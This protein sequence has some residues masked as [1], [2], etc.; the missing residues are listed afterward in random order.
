MGSCPRASSRWMR[1]SPEGFRGE[2]RACLADR[3]HRERRAWRF[4]QR[5]GSPTKGGTW[6]GCI[7]ALYRL[8]QR[9]GLASIRRGSFRFRPRVIWRLC[10]VRTPCFGGK[11]STSWYSTGSGLGGTGAVGTVFRD[12]SW[13]HR[14][15]YWFCLHRL[16]REILFGLSPRCTWPWNGHPR[17]RLEQCSWSWTRP[18]SVGLRDPTMPW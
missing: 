16:R 8:P 15:P 9:C 14:V 4:G 13:A 1:C 5:R 12:W 10:V 7:V 2:Q 3:R 17:S 11:R 18:A 6:R